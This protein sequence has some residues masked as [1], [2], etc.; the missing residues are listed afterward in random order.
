MSGGERER[1]RDRQAEV[2]H[3]GDRTGERQDVA[4]GVR[5]GNQRRASGVGRRRISLLRRRKPVCGLTASQSVEQSSQAVRQRGK[6]G[7]REKEREML[8][9]QPSR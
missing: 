4:A 7:E 3:T 9:L 1:E 6:E 5:S 8:F 2:R